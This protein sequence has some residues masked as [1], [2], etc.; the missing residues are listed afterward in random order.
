M[1]FLTAFRISTT[2]WFRRKK[3]SVDE[4]FDNKDKDTM[5]AGSEYRYLSGRITVVTGTRNRCGAMCRT[6]GWHWRGAKPRASIV[7]S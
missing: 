5:I 1:R 3:S 7:S 6:Y 2:R 4:P